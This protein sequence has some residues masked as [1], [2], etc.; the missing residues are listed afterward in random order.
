MSLHLQREMEKLKKKVLSLG[1]LVEENLRRA[2]ESVSNRDVQLAV[3]VVEADH[4]IDQ[5]EIDVEEE[6]LKILALYQPV[7]NDLR[8]IIAIV[9]INH[10][11]ERIGDLAAQI[12][13]SVQPLSQEAP[14]E[15]PFDF[16]AMSGKV[17]RIVKLAL[18][19]LVDLDSNLA[20]EAWAADKEVD[21]IHRGTYDKVKAAVR[22]QPDH[23]DTLIH[24]LSIS[25]AFERMADHAA[26]IAKDVIYMAEG[27]I[28]RH[29]GGKK[30]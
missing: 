12:A 2:V 27:E 29:R 16:P 3:R 24:C 11:L 10:D 21:A 7:A 25:R 1:A 15:I 4:E 26:N 18:D 17:Q 8:F 6:C 28:V 13:E 5:M 19:A 9:K 14:H 30:K 20:R 23:I 22:A